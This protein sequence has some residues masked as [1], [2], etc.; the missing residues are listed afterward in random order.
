MLHST[1]LS[2][3]AFV[4]S[5]TVANAFSLYSIN[6]RL[7]VYFVSVPL[8][9]TCNLYFKHLARIVGKSSNYM[10]TVTNMYLLFLCINTVHCYFQSISTN[11]KKKTQRS[12]CANHTRL[13][14]FVNVVFLKIMS[15]SMT[16]N[17]IC[18]RRKLFHKNVF[19]VC[20]LR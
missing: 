17:K 12:R 15:Q 13:E 5:K 8:Y 4:H 19:T 6:I 20:W 11:D 18:L 14:G 10:S 2:S 9:R 16:L 1:V 7:F 3:P